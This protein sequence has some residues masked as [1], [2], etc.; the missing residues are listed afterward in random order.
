[1]PTRIVLLSVADPVLVEEG[2]AEVLDRLNQPDP[3]L[4][5]LTRS[6]GNAVH[7]S[8]AA[9]ALVEA[10]G[11]LAAEAALST[12]TT[13]GASALREEEVTFSSTVQA[14]TT[15]SEG[16]TVCVEANDRGQTPWRGWPPLSKLAL[17]VVGGWTL[18]LREHVAL[19][20]TL[21]GAE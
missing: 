21:K 8:R 19:T 14:S 2:T 20:R 17:T 6:G 1:M 7:L 3:V 9:V 15:V 13:S 5:P 10:A 12:T 18:Q 11:D 4:V 16:R